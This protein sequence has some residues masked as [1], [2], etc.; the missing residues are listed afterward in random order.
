MQTRL[1]K[2]GALSNNA[3][4]EHCSKNAHRQTGEQQSTL[5]LASAYLKQL[6]VQ[7]SDVP[8]TLAQICN[9][10]AT[11]GSICLGFVYD[12]STKIAFFK[13]A[14]QY[15]QI[16]RSSSQCLY[17]NTTVWLLNTGTSLLYYGTIASCH[18]SCSLCATHVII[19]IM[20]SAL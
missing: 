12:A 20:T 15:K 8:D 10:M 19:M 18:F 5:R 13:G 11:N 6:G 1:F 4:G 2:L 17:P 9:D 7:E 3:T 14:G 16:D